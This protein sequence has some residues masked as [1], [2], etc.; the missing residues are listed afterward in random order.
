[1]WSAQSFASGCLLPA[2]PQIGI[3]KCF[4]R[5]KCSFGTGL[6]VGM[7][8]EAITSDWRCHLGSFH[9]G[10]KTLVES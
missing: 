4:E 5:A 10:E 8:E 3:L 1:M 2:A 7:C 9:I 6:P